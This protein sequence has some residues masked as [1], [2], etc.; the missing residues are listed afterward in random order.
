MVVELKTNHRS[1]GNLIFDNATKISRQQIPEFDKSA[2]FSLIVPGSSNVY[3]LPPKIRQ[4]T[5]KLA[6]S[7]LKPL[8]TVVTRRV[9]LISTLGKI[10]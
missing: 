4:G 7:T 8:D 3:K 9:S 6:P 2:G 5:V 1:E 10:F